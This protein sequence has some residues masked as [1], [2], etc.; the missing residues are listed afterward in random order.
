MVPRKIVLTYGMGDRKEELGKGEL[1]LHEK[2]TDE[3]GNLFETKIW[4]VP[5]S[6]RYRE[7]I[8]YRLAFVQYGESS[9]AVLYDN[10]HP[11]GHHRHFGPIEQAYDFQDV[12]HLIED[13]QRDVSRMKGGKP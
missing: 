9:P 6:G 12:D 2:T 5:V 1:L 4:R 3:E 13:F 11:K 7:G 8:R 10:H